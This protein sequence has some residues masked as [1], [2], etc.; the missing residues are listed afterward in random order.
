VLEASTSYGHG[1]SMLNGVQVKGL[2]DIHVIREEDI[3]A[4]AMLHVSPLGPWHQPTGCT[5]EEIA[6][7]IMN[8]STHPRVTPNTSNTAKPTGSGATTPGAD[9]TIYTDPPR[10]TPP[11]PRIL[12][13]PY[14]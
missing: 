3:S 13:V 14:R 11:I 1:E 12:P 9:S 4:K 5:L 2:G 10:H 7:L 6:R 8:V